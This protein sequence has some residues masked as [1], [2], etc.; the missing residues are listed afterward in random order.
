MPELKNTFQGGKMDKDKDERILP[1]GQYRD[2]MNVQVSTSDGSDVGVI[3]NILGNELSS[4]FN[5]F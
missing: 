1:N 5:R 4:S 2:A 3:Q